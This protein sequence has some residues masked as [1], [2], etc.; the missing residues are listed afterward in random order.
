[1]ETWDELYEK[2]CHQRWHYLD[3]GVHSG[4]ENMRIDECLMQKASYPTL[5]IYTWER[6]TLSLG[7]NQ[8]DNWLDYD[9]CRELG[10]DVVRRPTGGR[11]L[12]HLPDEITYAVILPDVSDVSVRCS[13]EGIAM[14]L[15][16]T[17]RCLGVPVETAQYS[18]VPRAKTFPHCGEVI[19][20]GEICWQGRKLVGSAQVRSM[21]HLLQHGSLLR[22]GDGGL[23][24]KIIPNAEPRLTLEEI[25]FGELQSS[26]IIIAWQELLANS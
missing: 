8:H 14:V 9:L 16:K 18:M 25:G 4:E 22:H 23:L 6:P 20:A 7:R 11:A 1:M 17:L 21:G 5:R 24:Q 13:F 15:N 2:L 12:L 3:D 26:D 19:T 10:V